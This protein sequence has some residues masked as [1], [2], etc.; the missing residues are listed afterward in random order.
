MKKELYLY[1]PIYDFSAEQL[2]AA[3]EENNGDDIVIRLNTPGGSVFAG[4]GIVAKMLER[5]GKTT[6]KVD[7]CAMSMGALLLPFADTVE[8]LDVTVIMLHRAHMYVSTPEDQAFLDKVNKTLRS[9]LEAKINVEKLKEI[10]GT[11][12]DDLF[13]AKDR[14]DLFLTAKQAKQ[15]GLVDKINSVDPKE[16]S[17]FHSKMFA[18]AAEHTPIKETTIKNNTMTIEKLKA[19]H[20]ALFAEV[21]AIGVAQEKDR[22]E[23]CLTFIEI[24]AVG[25]KAA[26]ESGKPLSQKQIADFALKGISA[27]TL[28]KVE[29][30]ST[31][32][33][34]TEE[35]KE[36]KTEAQKKIDA[37]EA[38]LLNLKK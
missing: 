5:G 1:S 16:L 31:K 37:F 34:K 13:T 12:I 35:V 14:I 21:V 38:E 25:V 19:E 2:I 23:A 7:G 29:G 18:V 28:K 11:S 17:A 26:I 15:I 8:A 36:A 20:P 32:E 24:D 10:T 30:E 9:K 3:M 6:I 27:T 22:V 4:W 33:I